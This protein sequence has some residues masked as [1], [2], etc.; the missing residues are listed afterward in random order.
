M[1][2]KVVGVRRTVLVLAMMAVG[3]VF[4]AS[5]AASAYEPAPDPEPTKRCDRGG[6]PCVGTDRRD[7][8]YGSKAADDIR[9]RAGDWDWAHGRPGDDALYG[10]ADDDSLR[11][12]RG[13]DD[14]HGGAGRDWLDGG[15]D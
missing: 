10:G 12:G 11:G 4:L 15:G 6:G 14:L 9:A 5:G 2:K 13:R 1:T 7:A 3:V 8:I